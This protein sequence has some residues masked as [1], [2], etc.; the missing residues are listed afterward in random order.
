MNLRRALVLAATAA[1]FAV[2]A[3]SASAATILVKDDLFS[4]KV[5]TYKKNT[6]V[7]FKWV[8]KS[9]H[10]VIARRSGKRIWTIGVRMSGKVKKRFTKTG[11][12]KLICSIHAPDMSATIKVV[13]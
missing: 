1:A 5:K 8:G 6:L 11:T 2:P 7:T 3:S 4:P 10:D 13:R 12:Y 9:P